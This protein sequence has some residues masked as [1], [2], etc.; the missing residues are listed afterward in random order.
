MLDGAS[1][2]LAEKSLADLLGVTPEDLRA[3]MV[4]ADL[5]KDFHW[6]PERS[7]PLVLAELEKRAL[8]VTARYDALPEQIPFAWFH[9]SRVP[10]PEIFQREGILPLT[11]VRPRLHKFLV[12]LSDGIE[13]KGA[14]PYATSISA[15]SGLPNDFGPHGFMLRSQAVLA[16]GATHQYMD[17][18]EAVEDYAGRFGSNS[19][20]LV[21][22]YWTQTRAC[23]SGSV[24]RGRGGNW[25]GSR[26]TSR[27]GR[28]ELTRRMR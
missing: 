20:V 18:P 23:W 28:A 9:A 17:A 19:T 1:W 25:S 2:E 16:P 13:A 12:T 14:N 26:R 27:F 11:V 10:D 22:R 4:A 21:E 3:A 5:P 6:E 24:G 15:K 8:S 7:L